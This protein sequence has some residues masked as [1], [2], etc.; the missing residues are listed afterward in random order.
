MIEAAIPVAGMS[1]LAAIALLSAM[2]F[3]ASE[4]SIAKLTHAAVEDLI[5]D[6]KKNARALF[7]LVDRRRLVIF[8]LRGVRTFLQVV[9]A[10]S[11]ATIALHFSHHW[12]LGGLVAIVVVTIVQFFANSIIA[13]RWAQR[14]P[15][16]IALFFTPLMS[17]R[18]CTFLLAGRPEG[19]DLSSTV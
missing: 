10:V 8:V 7:K 2:V 11:M 13:T 15:T 12:W 19:Q 6:D 9:F 17:R 18:Y 16:G 4:F 14:N 1:I 5:E 3:A